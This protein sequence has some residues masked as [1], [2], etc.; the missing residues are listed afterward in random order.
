MTSHVNYFEIYMLSLSLC[1]NFT[2]VYDT[3]SGTLNFPVNVDNRLWFPT[4]ADIRN[5]VSSN[6]LEN[7][8]SF[9]L[10]GLIRLIF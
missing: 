5:H 10:V 1:Y 4:V 3:V 6:S 2:I 9:R 7:P 8:S